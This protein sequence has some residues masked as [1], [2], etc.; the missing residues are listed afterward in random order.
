MSR[1]VQGTA[2]GSGVSR[3]DFLVGAG[4]GI[5]LAAT[6]SL[7]GCGTSSGDDIEWDK[8]VDLVVV[9]GGLGL[10]GAAFAAEQG[11]AVVL[12]EK[13]DELG[14]NTALSG[15]VFWMPMHGMA[16]D[17]DN[18]EDVLTYIKHS[19]F[20]QNVDDAW[21]AGFLDANK[22]AAEWAVAATGLSASVFEWFGDYHPE[23]KGA[24]QLGRSIYFHKEG[25]TYTAQAGSVAFISALADRFSAK[26][27]EI[28]TGTA[29]TRLIYRQQESGVPEVIGVEAKGA[30]GAVTKIKARKGILLA[31]GGFGWNQEWKDHY[32]AAPIPFSGSAPGQD[33]DGQ[34]LAMSVGADL[35]CMKTA[36]GH[37]SY[38]A[39]AEEANKQGGAAPITFDYHKAGAILVNKRG[40][41]F[42]DEASD[43][44]ALWRTTGAWE[45]WG[46][47]G[48][49]N[50]PMWLIADDAMVNGVGMDPRSKAVNTP[51]PLPFMVKA[52]TLEELAAAVGI[53]PAGL[54]AEVA[55][56]NGFV[57]KQKDDD[58]HRGE[59]FIDQAMMTG[60]ATISVAATLGRIATPPFYAAEMTNIE[61]GTA[62]GPKINENSQVVHVSGEPVAR[63]YA[64]GNN[65]GWGGFYGGAG[66]T[67]G[68][69]LTTNYVAAKHAAALE[70]WK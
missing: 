66:G 29:A 22:P 59:S 49:A 54:V 19:A 32:L 38:K 26:G 58:F 40:K 17:Q 9:G 13:N 63:L 53:D 30:D 8:E 37:L 61:I 7:V 2:G 34:K 23:W 64:S 43:Y 52:N 6:S 21:L 35:R 60:A 1:N 12:L 15:G 57:D 4:A 56:S 25:E 27:G 70:P 55:K 62:G 47:N 45:N 68:P 28:L 44:A 10:A 48:Y 46:D 51:G 18:R 67:L 14:G 69:A 20:E 11:D 3:R 16:G 36:W 31:A 50:Q 42:C 5:A 41:R 65:A 33:G 24:R 39:L